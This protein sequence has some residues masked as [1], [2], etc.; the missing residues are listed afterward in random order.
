MFSLSRRRM[1]SILDDALL[2]AQIDV[3]GEK[4]RSSPV[5]LGMALRM[6]VERTA[7]FA[8][9]R[10]VRLNPLARGLGLVQGNEE[11]LV[12]AFHALLDTAVKFSEEGASVRLG[13]ESGAG[14]RSIV[15]ESRGRTIP[16][17]ALARFFDIFSIGEAL[18]PGGDLGLGPAVAYRIF[19]LFGGSVS[20][21]NVNGHGIRLTVALPP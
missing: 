11:L 13:Y 9:S 12:R 15:I 8:E 5:S 6:A 3:G 19:L 4:L 7:G 20:V 14:S 10:N 1:L 21:A 2:L 17:P 18:T 16:S